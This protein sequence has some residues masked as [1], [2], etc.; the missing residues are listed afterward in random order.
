MSIAEGSAVSL[1]YKA[2][3]VGTMTAATEDTA[4]GAT[5]GQVLR[6]T[7]SGLN[8]R[9]NSTKSAEILPSRQ[10]RSSR[11][12]SRR[13]EGSI[14]GEL[15]PGTYFDLFE[16]VLRGTRVTGVSS[17][18]VI[19]PA[20]G[21][22]KRKFMFERYNADLDISRKY[23]ECR[24][25]GF[26]IN[27]PAEGNSTVEFMVMGR[28]RS[29]VSA[30]SAP[31]LT[32]P[33]A[34]TTSE[35][36]N[37]LSGSITVAGVAVGLVTSIQIGATNSSEAPAVLGQQFPPDI[38]LGSLDVSGSI[39]FLL[40]SADTA[41]TIFE[42]ETEV[43]I[44]LT[45][46]NAT[47]GGDSVTISLPRVKLNSADEETRGD[48]SQPVSCSFQALEATSGGILSTIQIEDTSLHS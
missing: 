23:T 3:S 45:L 14:S 35:V 40:D 30:S 42:A 21:H 4:P 46:T 19:A 41:A 47:S 17:S 8:L 18:V 13:V 25:T 48:L 12:T 34:A 7:Q 37:S 39:T 6:Y 24:V 36:C 33:T 38:L 22:V 32:A 15:S 44:V 16:A 26:R 9:V 29:T 1:R 43:A 5:G 27:T 2:Y 31:Y 28:N 20:S 11:R 10:T